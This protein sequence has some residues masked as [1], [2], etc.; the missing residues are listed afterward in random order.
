MVC[1][2]GELYAYDLSFTAIRALDVACTSRD[3]IGCLRRENVNCLA[4]CAELD[5][6]GCKA[7]IASLHIMLPAMQRR[8]VC[9]SLRALYYCGYE[10][11]HGQIQLSKEDEVATGGEEIE[12][13]RE[14][15]DKINKFSR[16]HNRELVIEEELKA[17][18]VRSLAHTEHT[19]GSNTVRRKKRRIS[20]RSP[21]NWSLQMRMT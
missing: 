8:M 10:L 20:R 5:H 6:S 7:P 11:K 1:N 13:R 15:Q 18:Q 2:C 4:H 3:S 17:K 16:L 19:L 14:D 9:I 12:V 21:A